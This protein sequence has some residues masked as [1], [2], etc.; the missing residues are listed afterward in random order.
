MSQLPIHL[1]GDT[2]CA[3]LR[4]N[5][6]SLYLFQ[7]GQ[8]LWGRQRWHVTMAMCSQALPLR[9]KRLCSSKNGL[10]GMSLKYSVLYW[11]SSRQNTQHATEGIPL[12]ELH[13]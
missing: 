5:D 9:M 7:Q 6:A 3:V 12:R 10:R 11:P 4:D 2:S 1:V 13:V 8:A